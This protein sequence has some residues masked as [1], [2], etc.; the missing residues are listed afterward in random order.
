[1]EV[2]EFTANVEVL[3]QERVWHLKE[4]QL[5]RVLHRRHLTSG[6][7]GPG[8]GT[9]RWGIGSHRRKPLR[10]PVEVVVPDG[11]SVHAVHF[12]ELPAPRSGQTEVRRTQGQ[13]RARRPP[14]VAGGRAASCPGLGIASKR[15]Q[16]GAP[17]PTAG[18]FDRYYSTFFEN[19]RL[20]NTFDVVLTDGNVL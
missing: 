9:C 4:E 20:G 1:V 12:R 17:M 16:G 5:W 19:A 6:H 7:P 8:G 3:L 2:A 18:S 10:R 14:G 15:P 13:P 11:S